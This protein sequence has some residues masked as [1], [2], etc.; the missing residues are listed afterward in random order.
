MNQTIRLGRN[1]TIGE[2][3]ET[4]SA[5][6]VRVGG[7]ATSVNL[8]IG[9]VKRAENI[10]RCGVVYGSSNSCR[11]PSSLQN[12]VC[13]CFC[14]SSPKN[15]PPEHFPKEIDCLVVAN[16]RDGTQLSVSYCSLIVEMFDCQFLDA[17]YMFLRE[18][19]FCAS[20]APDVHDSMKCT[21][22]LT[23]RR[24][25]VPVI[26]VAHH[27][28]RASQKH[29][30]PNHKTRCDRRDGRQPSP[31]LYRPRA[32]VGSGRNRGPSGPV[33]RRTLGGGCTL[34]SPRRANCTK[35]V[36][37][38]EGGYTFGLPY[39]LSPPR[40][41]G[42]ST[43]PPLLLPHPPNRRAV[44]VQAGLPSISTIT[45]RFVVGNHVLSARSNHE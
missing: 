25:P 40:V 11:H 30:V 31:D 16:R 39:L 5:V 38:G 7:W 29:M 4:G 21:I 36:Q 20:L 3:V 37:K 8:T 42:V 17:N 23:S 12:I 41:D 32:G 6:R 19:R 44:E 28:G 18:A 15:T 27:D 2:A 22:I 43:I 10:Y 1:H 35:I 14:S 45:S 9:Q 26:G 34:G 33:R 13:A 24:R